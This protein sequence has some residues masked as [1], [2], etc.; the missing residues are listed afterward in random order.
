MIA[1]FADS[2]IGTIIEVSDAQIILSI[3]SM[4]IDAI[5]V[6]GKRRK[7]LAA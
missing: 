1:H 4:C 7:A 3:C 6:D 5:Y 2:T